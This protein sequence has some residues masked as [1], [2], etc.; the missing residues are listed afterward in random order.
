[1]LGSPGE[2]ASVRIVEASGV[3][4]QGLGFVTGERYSRIDSTQ[5]P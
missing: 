5:Q 2:K 4:A 3:L 1:M